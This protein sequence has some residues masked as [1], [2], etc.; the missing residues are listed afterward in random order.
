VDG[1]DDDRARRKNQGDFYHADLITA[2]TPVPATAIPTAIAAAVASGITSTII[3]ARARRAAVASTNP[4]SG[5]ASA[6]F[7]LRPV[8]HNTAEVSIDVI[9][10]AVDERAVV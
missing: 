1:Q 10:D 7:L 4:R 9:H 5:V 2:S 3:D 8:R 6:A